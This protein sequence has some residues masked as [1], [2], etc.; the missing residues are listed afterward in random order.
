MS[1]KPQT[2][3]ECSRKKIKCQKVIPCSNCEKRGIAHLCKLAEVTPVVERRMPCPPSL[4]FSPGA[5][6]AA[7]VPAGSTIDVSLNE[8]ILSLVTTLSDRVKHLETKLDGLQP[9]KRRAAEEIDE[10]DEERAVDV[11]QKRHS[12]LPRTAAP[13]RPEASHPGENE[14]S[15]ENNSSR[16]SREFDAEAEDAATVLEFLAWGRLKDSSLTSGLR[17]PSIVQDPMMYSDKDIVQTTQAWGLSPGSASGSQPSTETMHV[18]QI[19]DLLPSKEQAMLL[20]EYHGDWLLF[21]HCSFHVPSLRQELLNFYQNE[22]GI[23]NMTSSG[24]QW[25]ALFL[26]VICGSMVCAKPTQIQEWGYSEDNQAKLS[27][28]WYHA[29]VKCLN[30]ARYQQNHCLFGVQAISSST[31]CAHLLGFSNSQS[32]MLASAIRVAQSLGLHRLPRSNHAS[33]G[34]HDTSSV[35][36]IQAEVGRRVWQQ[37]A[38]QDWF[39]VPFSE[40]YCINPLH[41]TTNPPSHCDENT[42][43]SLPL[44]IP[45]IMSYGNFLFR[46][47]ALMPALLDQCSKAHN[48]NTKYEEVLRFDQMMR[49]IV[50]SELP[51]CL[52][53]QTLV[54]DSWP[55]WIVLARRCLTVTSAHKIIMIHRRF[56]G[57][58]FHDKRY[59]FTR[60]T[61][62]AAA[63][64]IINE[65][66]QDLP[67]ESPILWTMQAFSVAAAIILSLDNFNSR[68]SAREHA[69]HRQ[70]VLDTI[71]VL[72]ASTAISSIASR[73]TRLLAEL[74]E[75]EQKH[76]QSVGYNQESRSS[77]GHRSKTRTISQKTSDRNLNVSEFVKKF[78]QSD[79]PLP[80][81]SPIATSHVPLWLQQES[82]YRS[83]PETY[84]RIDQGIRPTS[85]NFPSYPPHNFRTFHDISAPSAHR[86]EIS[87]DAFAQ[88]ISDNFDIRSMNWFDDLLGLAPSNSI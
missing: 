32:V 73:G 42:M 88:N 21:M 36:F 54:D 86:H 70:L 34:G 79:Q 18:S 45:G 60:R 7:P 27:K 22:Q 33:A 44:S 56:L 16:T 83:C 77:N 11:S 25:T 20:F 66:K 75:E 87:H 67:E 49:D 55:K 3:G 43:K 6:E 81:N 8:K 48:L 14:P 37:L 72:S 40:T 13:E 85:G 78:C 80:G 26:S 35:E 53:S 41:F 61:C 50:M 65:V 52:N 19:Q 4:V 12:K 28:Q 39:S 15:T 5:A 2:C 57:M 17:D 31:I 51:S 9:R 29:S 46:I 76:S 82:T 10:R 74:L 63:K 24:L 71:T 64:T 69:D 47:A 38:T 1:R 68:Q 30:A 58:S 62:L 23:I 84:G 59:A